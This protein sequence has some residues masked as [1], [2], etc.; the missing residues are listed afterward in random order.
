MKA[1][2]LRNQDK[3]TLEATLADLFKKQFQLRMQHGNGQLPSND[4]LRKVRKDIARVKTL[5]TEKAN[6]KGGV[7]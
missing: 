2:E 6:N 5:M 7:E 3:S 4:R 1:N